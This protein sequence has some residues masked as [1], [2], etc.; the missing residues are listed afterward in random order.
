MLIITREETDPFINLAT[1]E[2]IFRTFDA[3]LFM[4]WINRPAIIIGKHQNA[5]S[6]IN[7][8]FVQDNGIPV[9]RRITGGGTVYHDEGNL[10]YTFILKGQPGKLI[11][12]PAYTRPVI[13]ALKE[14]GIEAMLTGKS[15]LTI[16]GLKFSGNSEH[17]YK[18]K[19][20]HHGTLLFDSNLNILNKALT[21]KGLHYHDKAVRSKR[22]QVT[23]IACHL[24]VPM[25]IHGFK[26]FLEDYVSRAFSPADKVSLTHRE[27]QIIREL[28]EKKYTSWEWNYG[29]SPPFVF[30]KKNI[31]PDRD[32][33]M[34]ISNGIIREFSLTNGAN[35]KTEK[36]LRKALIHA[37][38]H[39]ADMRN[40]LKTLTFAGSITAKDADKL[41]DEIF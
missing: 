30:H 33:E 27:H 17:I 8:R 26:V 13:D 32:L 22:S 2:Y 11:D 4:L 41:I 36:D 12:Y 25:G 18:D 40:K 16:S 34:K 38:F 39:P 9:I 5:F 21:S 28:A 29:H 35:R 10:N 14:L 23:N 37:R 1:E 3:P 20:I 24:P 15:D 6:E 31:M 7:H 19:V